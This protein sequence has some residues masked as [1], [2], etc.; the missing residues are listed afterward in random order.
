MWKRVLVFVTA[1][2]VSAAALSGQQPATKIGP[3]YGPAKGA[4]VIVGGGATEG[5]GIMEK[6][7]ELAGGPN[8]KFVIVPTAGGNRNA[9]G[10]L[11]DYKED[12]TI[13]GWR[14][15]GLKNVTMLHAA[16]K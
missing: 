3:E 11:I 1:T 5:T 10:A 8:A 7:I 14:K 4:L 9:S 2:L 6:F 13:A 16:L 12:E 15:R